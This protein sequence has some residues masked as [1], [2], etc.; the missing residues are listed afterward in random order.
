MT[1]NVSF[2]VNFCEMITVKV[3]M[4][5]SLR[6]VAPHAAAPPPVPPPAVHRRAT[7]RLDR[8]VQALPQ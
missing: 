1:V 7:A 3:V 2:P 4:E 8:S 5:V 6:D